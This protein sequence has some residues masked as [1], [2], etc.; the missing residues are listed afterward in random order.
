MDATNMTD[1][2]L[3]FPDQP[4]ALAAFAALGM[5]HDDQLSQGSHQF[6]LHE[7]GEIPGLEGW[8][9]NLR[10]IDPALDVSSLEPFAVFPTSPRCVWA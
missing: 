9:I 1:H 2:F 10:V 3:K 5:T 8:H 4:A 6:A 7:V